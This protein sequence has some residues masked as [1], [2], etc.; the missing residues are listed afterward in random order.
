MAIPLSFG[1]KTPETQLSMGELIG[2]MHDI[3][4]HINSLVGK[5]AAITDPL[6][7]AEIEV[8]IAEKLFFLQDFTAK[9]GKAFLNRVHRNALYANKLISGMDIRSLLSRYPNPIASLENY[10]KRSSDNLDRFVREAREGMEM[11]Y[12][13]RRYAGN[14]KGRVKSNVSAAIKSVGQK[15]AT[16]QKQQ[17]AERRKRELAAKRQQE[18]PQ[19]SRQDEEYKKSKLEQW[20]R[21]EK[22]RDLGVLGEREKREFEKRAR[23]KVRR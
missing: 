12:G 14:V 2:K 1:A 10:K 4:R 3:M 23:E 22:L 19:Y 9:L 13:L 21:M 7:R 20:R 5:Y 18:Q 8:Q 16:I 15:A 11:W 17:E 6:Q